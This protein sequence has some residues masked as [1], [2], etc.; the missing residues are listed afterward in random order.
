MTGPRSIRANRNETA[1]ETATVMSA[2]RRSC[3][4][5]DEEFKDEETTKYEITVSG[6]I[7]NEE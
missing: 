7:V 5:E 6:A 2:Y 1:T 4:I 3:G